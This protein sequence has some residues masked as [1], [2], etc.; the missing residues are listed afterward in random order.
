MEQRRERT[1]RCGVNNSR[2]SEMMGARI[3][4]CFWT[5]VIFLAVL[6]LEPAILLGAAAWLTRALRGSKSAMVPLAVRYS[7][8]LVPLGALAAP[9]QVQKERDDFGRALANQQGDSSQSHDQAGHARPAG[10]HRGY[11]TG[12]ERSHYWPAARDPRPRS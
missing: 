1:E 9:Q 4:F 5:G 2:H 7:Y 8:A 10:F 3:G 12:A 11:R 6:V